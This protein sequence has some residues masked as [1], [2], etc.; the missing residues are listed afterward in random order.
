VACEM[1]RKEVATALIKAGANVNEN[2]NK[3]HL[4][5]I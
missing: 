1:D 4:I 5:N 3:V 2:N